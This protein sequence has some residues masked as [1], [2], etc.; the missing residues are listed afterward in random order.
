MP[1]LRGVPRDDDVV[2]RLAALNGFIGEILILQGVFVVHKIWAALRG[3][4]DRARRRLHAL[5]LSAHDVRQDR[6]SRECGDEG[7]ERA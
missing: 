1:V 4:R 3:E 5:A 2:D 7:S 6:Q